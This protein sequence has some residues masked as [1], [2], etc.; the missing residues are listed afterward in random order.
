M[1][2]RETMEKLMIA[3]KKCGCEEPI[4][5]IDELESVYGSMVSPAFLSVHLNGC[6]QAEVE[7]GTSPML[8]DIFELKGMVG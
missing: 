1:K 5:G 8:S 2:G 7:N 4:G 3:C 6:H